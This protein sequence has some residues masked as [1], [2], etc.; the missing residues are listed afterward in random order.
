[1][2]KSAKSTLIT[3]ASSIF[4]RRDFNMRQ[5]RWLEAL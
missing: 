1:M 3:K 5:R 4:S 2:V